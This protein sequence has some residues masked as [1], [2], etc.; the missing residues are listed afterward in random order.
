MRRLL[1]AGIVYLT[2]MA[3]ILVI[4]PSFMFNSDGNWKEFGVGRNPATHTILPV[5][6]F[7][8]LWAL[9]SYLIVSL[10]FIAYNVQSEPTIVE[11]DVSIVRPKRGKAKPT[12][13][14]IPE[15]FASA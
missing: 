1:V 9:L 4:K 2:G 3:T 14:E 13:V 11:E 7:A 5:W 12:A 15:A 10:L 6:L 8:V